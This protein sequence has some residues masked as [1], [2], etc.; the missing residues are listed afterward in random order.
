MNPPPTPKN[1]ARKPMATLMTAALQWART[2]WPDLVL[3]IVCDR[4]PPFDCGAPVEFIPWT[5]EVEVEAVRTADIGLMPL[6]NDEWTSGKCGYKVLQYMACGLPSISA[7]YGIISDMI[8]AGTCG[9]AAQDTEEWQDGF[10]RLIDDKEL[11]R[12]VGETARY[13]AETIYS[14]KAVY[15]RWRDVLEM[16]LPSNGTAT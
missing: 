2:K 5:P 3:R 7:P 14:L 8:D 13:R 4:P 6:P 16:Q 10:E 11:R 9:L 1:A 15:P 12:L